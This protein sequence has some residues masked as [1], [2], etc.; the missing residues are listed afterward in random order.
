MAT[1]LQQYDHCRHGNG[2]WDSGEVQ[3][4]PMTELSIWEG[5]KENASRPNAELAGYTC[6]VHIENMHVC[7]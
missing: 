5:M 2:E 6:I 7:M 3:G 4:M 1:G